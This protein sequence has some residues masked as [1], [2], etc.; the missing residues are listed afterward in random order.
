MAETQKPHV[1]M[2]PMVQSVLHR[3]MRADPSSIRAGLGDIMSWLEQESVATADRETTELVLAELLNNIAE[4]GYPAEKAGSLSVELN[5]CDSDIALSISDSG[6]EMP[7]GTL[8]KGELPES[9]GPVD[10]LPEGGF[11]WFLI[12][13]LTKELSYNRIANKNL[14][15]FRIPL[16]VRAK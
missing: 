7:G 4:H 10:D 6:I 8:P 11:G 14:L 9:G 15:F 13:S 2:P 5:L 1:P 12:Y 3:T 16:S